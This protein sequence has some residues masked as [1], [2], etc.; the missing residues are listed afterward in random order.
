MAMPLRYAYWIV[1][2]KATAKLPKIAAFSD[3]LLAEA[4]EDIRQLKTLGSKPGRAKRA[5]PVR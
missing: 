4:T 1:C 2:P 3:W 5:Q